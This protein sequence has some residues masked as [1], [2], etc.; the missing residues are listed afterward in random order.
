M[1]KGV[2]D[3][4][5]DHPGPRRGDHADPRLDREPAERR[6]LVHLEL[7]RHLEPD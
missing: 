3:Q 2:A 7:V 5:H 6:E 1:R 4:R